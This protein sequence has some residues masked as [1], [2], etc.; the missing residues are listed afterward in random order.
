MAFQDLSEY[1]QTLERKGELA[2]IKFEVDWNLEMTEIIDRTVK[3]GGPALFFENVNGY[4]IPVAA[5]LFGTY[6]RVKLVLG[7]DPDE[8]AKEI[9]SLLKPEIP[10]TIW[11]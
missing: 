7:G 3:R 10:E 8:I 4:D 9:A 6:E 11:E 2:R 5:N 1:L